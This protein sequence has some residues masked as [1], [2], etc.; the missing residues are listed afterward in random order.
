MTIKPTSDYPTAIEA[1]NLKGSLPIT[2]VIDPS[3]NVNE[4]VTEILQRLA[5]VLAERRPE[6][7]AD[8]FIQD[9]LWRDLIIFTG[10]YRTFHSNTLIG[11]VWSN[12]CLRTKPDNFKPVTLEQM[13]PHIVKVKS[14][15]NFIKAFC[16]F[17][18]QNP[19]A[20]GS[21]N[22]SI[23]YDSSTSSWKI[24]S[25]CT[26]L[27]EFQEFQGINPFNGMR[28][29]LFARDE[30]GQRYEGGY[31]EELPKDFVPTESHGFGDGYGVDSGNGYMD[32]LYGHTGN[33]T[34]A[35]PLTG[36]DTAVIANGH[37]HPHQNGI[38][39]SKTNGHSLPSQH[40]R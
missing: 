24:W 27:E 34:F 23:V 13:L 29:N 4:V 8:L 28:T 12:L 14:N 9:A 22:L 3:T 1:S 36:A 16:T 40:P 26:I 15:L 20:F 11:K 35:L 21:A 25:I 7:I 6:S 2:E 5:N 39:Y 38:E 17:E 30:I 31:Y 33:F 18:T 32:R 19:K 37:S 10:T